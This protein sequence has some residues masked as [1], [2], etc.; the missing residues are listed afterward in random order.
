M[1][2]SIFERE[3]FDLGRNK[4]YLIV[5]CVGV[6]NRLLIDGKDGYQ[7]LIGWNIKKENNNEEDFIKNLNFRK[8]LDSD[9]FIELNFIKE[10]M[11]DKE[12]EF[13]ISEEHERN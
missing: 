7:Y 2:N 3:K 1:K 13:I 5:E 12:M 9:F 8:N 6:K 11:K 4:I 10:Y